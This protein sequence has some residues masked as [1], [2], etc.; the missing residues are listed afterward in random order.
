MCRWRS[1]I[2]VKCWPIGYFSSFRSSSTT[3]T[4]RQCRS[5]LSIIKLRLLKET[6]WQISHFTRMKDLNISFQSIN[7]LWWS[8]F[9]LQRREL[10]ALHGMRKNSTH[11]INCDEFFVWLFLQFTIIS[12]TN[13]SQWWWLP[14][15][16]NYKIELLH[17][18][19]PKWDWSSSVVLLICSFIFHLGTVATTA[20]LD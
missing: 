7:E 9:L 14:R 16:N 10:R 1:A 15:I 8:Y 18:R 6:L 2:K 3:S 20:N 11:V 19:C 5:S 17:F 13:V 12:I 4:R